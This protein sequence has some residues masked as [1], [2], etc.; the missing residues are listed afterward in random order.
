VGNPLQLVNDIFQPVFQQP[1][2][3][4]LIVIYEMIAHVLPVGAFAA[5]IVVLTLLLRCAMI[6]L[7]RKQLKSSREM[8]VLAPR[9]KELQAQY[10]NSPQELMAAQRALYKEHGVSPASGC[11]PLLVQMPFLYALYGAFLTVLPRTSTPASE[12]LKN[13]NA[14]LYPFVPQLTA[15]PNTHFLWT[16]LASPDPLHILPIVAAILTFIQLRMA[17]PV[18]PKPAPGTA[19]QPDPTTQATSM[20]QYI[21]PFF[22]LFI[23][24]TFASGLALYWT[25][26]TA[27]SAGQQYF[28]SGLGSLF[29]GVPGME[30][31]VPEPKLPP[32]PTTSRAPAT[33]RALTAA[34]P[35]QPPA[36]GGLRGMLKQI[37][38]SMAAA[39]SQTAEQ[40]QQQAAAPKAPTSPA[41]PAKSETTGASAPRRARPS[42]GGPM[43]I[44][45]AA[46][47]RDDELPEQAITRDATDKR[48]ENG[49]LPEQAIARLAASDGVGDLNGTGAG[50]GNG[51]GNGSSKNA[52]NGATPT[53]GNNG[54]SA[55][56]GVNGVSGAKRA[57]TNA[58]GASGTRPRPGTAPRKSGGNKNMNAPRPRGSRPKGG[59]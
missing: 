28:L 25:V 12:I 54:K 23:G 2:F 36:E 37:R 35:A 8:Q 1:V 58:N 26:S 42:R 16:N 43:L 24:W 11:L 6:P 13:I 38:D 10:R 3:N 59:R 15:L 33:A 31:L 30:H 47:K 7:T 50:N 27:F 46:G 52:Q 22:T 44:K 14:H 18:R 41:A 19:T 57:A 55:Q 34:A 29:V 40:R 45:P 39:Q 56:N 9:L 32:T 17:M 53:A 48:P 49:E 20:M 4:L 21:M 5:A 51:N